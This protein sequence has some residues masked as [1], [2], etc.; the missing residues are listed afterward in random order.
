MNTGT[1][2]NVGRGG[3]ARKKER[4]LVALRFLREQKAFA[5]L[6]VL[7]I[8]FLAAATLWL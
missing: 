2:H 6:A 1:R 7:S 8:V 5:F 3:A 4:D